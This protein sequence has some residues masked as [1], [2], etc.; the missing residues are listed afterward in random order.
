MTR[1]ARPPCSD[2][3]RSSDD[4][5]GNVTTITD[6]LS[7]TR[8]FTYDPTFNQATSTT[9]P[10]GNTTSFTYDD[11]GNLA[12]ASDPLGNFRYFLP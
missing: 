12:S 4:A 10:L 8:T 2:W 11:L 7:S 1:T 9:D 6:P 3:Q 5:R